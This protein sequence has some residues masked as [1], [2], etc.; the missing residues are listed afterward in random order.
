PLDTERTL[1]RVQ[2]GTLRV[3]ITHSPPWTD[4]SDAPPSGSE[5]DLTTDFAADLGA[6]IEWTLDSEAR[7]IE[8]IHRGELDL[9][10]GG[11][12]DDTPWSGKAAVTAPYLETTDESGRTAKHVLITRPGENGFLVRL[13]SFLAERGTR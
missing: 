8:D 4:T 1:E 2:G 12:T 3:G 9:V 13:E 7:L 5:V 11:F 10:I 6:E